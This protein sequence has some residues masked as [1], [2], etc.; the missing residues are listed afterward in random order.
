MIE[1]TAAFATDAMGAQVLSG[2]PSRV[3]RGGVI[4]SRKIQGDEIFFA[5][6]GTQVD[7][8][9]FAKTAAERGAAAVVVHQDLDP[10]GD[11]VWLRVDDT[12][13]ALHDLTRAI[14]KEVPENLVGITGSAGKTTTKEMLT[15]ILARSFRV[16]KSPGNLNNLHGFPLA[17]LSID[18]PCQWMVAEM[19]MST[20]GELRGVSLLGRPDVAVFTNVRPAHLM[21]FPNLRGITEAKAGLL[22]GLAPGGLVVVNADDPEVC[23]IAEH[24]TAPDSRILTYGFQKAADVQ[25]SHLES[26]EDRVGS[27][28]RLRAG[29]REQEIEVPVHGFYNAE[30]CLA[31]AACAWGLGVP[32]EEI[33]QATAEF[34]SGSMRGQV[35]T[36]ASG[37]TLIDDTYNSN[38]DAAVKAL[39]SAYALSAQRRLAILGDMLELGPEEEAYHAQVGQRA[40][41]LGFRVFGVGSLASALTRAAQEAG[42]EAEHFADAGSVAQRAQQLRD[43]LQGQDLI[44]VKGSRGVGLE[45]VVEALRTGSE[46]KG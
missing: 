43:N 11:A 44:L 10:V 28:F 21:N 1:R 41:E 45:V 15:P 39:E 33:A 14:R 31:A 37:A 20:P 5:L 16:E 36:L 24:H 8:H 34:Q 46:E 30:N 3:F 12:F 42:A 32:L 2:D 9:R 23:H 17:L 40:A 22:A 29:G 27:R 13:G 38:P 35:H 18:E 26:L 25:G 19:G 6:P 7:G 4:D